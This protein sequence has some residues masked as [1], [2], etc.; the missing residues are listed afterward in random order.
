MVT[1]ANGMPQFYSRAG[2][3]ARQEDIAGAVRMDE[4]LSRNWSSH[5]K[6]H[7]IG[8]ESEFQ[9]KLVRV[10]HTIMDII[11]EKDTSQASLF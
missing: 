11:D 9:M 6:F 8:N 1:P 5:P 3:A 2:N 4:I 10:I 7:C